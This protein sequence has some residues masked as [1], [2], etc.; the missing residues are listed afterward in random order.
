MNVREEVPIGPQSAA[1]ARRLL[2]SLRGKIP[3]EVLIDARLVLS[4]IITNSYKHAGNPEGTPIRIVLRY[5]G[6]R[7]RLE[8]IDQSVFD[9]T[10]ESDEQLRSTR[11]G[12]ILV[13]RLAHDWG[14]IS[15][16]GLWVE[17]KL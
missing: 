5:S 6:E 3:E 8:V 16:G 13:D 17:F 4:E 10:P 14:R 11:W 1:H 9:P 15:E 7:L 2:D 12:L